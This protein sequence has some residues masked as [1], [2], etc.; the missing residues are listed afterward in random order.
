MVGFSRL[1]LEEDVSQ[2]RQQGE[3][4]QGDALEYPIDAV[5][6]L[7]SEQFATLNSL[8]V[9]IGCPTE[10]QEEANCNNVSIYIKN[11]K[12]CRAC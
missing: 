12:I 11:I 8:V 1:S 7:L 10:E 6:R 9:V 2:G 3:G 5:D 4:D